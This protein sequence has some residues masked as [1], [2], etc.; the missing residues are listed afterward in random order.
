MP[1]R[2]RGYDRVTRALDAVQEQLDDAWKSLVSFAREIEDLVRA[3]ADRAE[4]PE[5]RPWAPKKS[6]T[7]RRPGRKAEPRSDYR[8]M[9][10][11][12]SGK[13]FRS[14]AVVLDQPRNLIRISV[15]AGG[16][17]YAKYFVG[18]SSR[19]PARPMM[20]SHE[21]GGSKE[22]L[23]QWR[24]RVIDSIVRNFEGA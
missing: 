10:G 9:I 21:A 18:Y 20:P 5:G 15:G 6:V 1:V 3:S 22:A 19:Q 17:R 12:R 14:I 24:K 8:P 11:V 13:M 23:D 7:V 16:A 2:V 4:T